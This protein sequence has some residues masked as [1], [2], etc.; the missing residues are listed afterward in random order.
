MRDPA[1]ARDVPAGPLV[2]PPGVKLYGVIVGKGTGRREDYDMVRRTLPTMA[3]PAWESQ[4]AKHMR[5]KLVGIVQ[6]THSVK[7]DMCTT[8]PWA[9]GPICNVIAHAAWLPEFVDS[10]GGQGVHPIKGALGIVEK[11]RSQTQA[12]L[13]CKTQGCQLHPATGDMGTRKRRRRST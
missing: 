1:N 7:T 6:I 3:I 13:V 8:S 11:V 2:A 4:Q 10:V 5:G 12:A 9:Q